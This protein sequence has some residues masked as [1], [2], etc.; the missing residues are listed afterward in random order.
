MIIVAIGANL[1]AD[2]F[3]TPLET[4]R[5]AVERLA[6]EPGLAVTAT[7]RWYE[8]EPVPPSG[9]PWYVNGAVTVETALGPAELLARLH[10]VEA[11]FG[12]VRRIRNE[13]RPLDLDLIDHDG[14][15]CDGRDGGPALPHPRARERAFVLLPLADV[16]PAWRHPGT[17]E[18]I[19]ELISALPAD[20]PAI[21][22]IDD[23]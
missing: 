19:R 16:A 17:G 6:G 20:G 2:G 23:R 1:P 15:L 4:C 7:S 3:A 13:A 21:R 11:S 22:P 8:S 9:Q 5:A 14:V 18:A 10:A 12:R